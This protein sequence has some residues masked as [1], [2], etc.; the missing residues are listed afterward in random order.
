MAEARVLST[1]VRVGLDTRSEKYALQSAEI[2]FDGF[3][4]L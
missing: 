1:N 2:L 3:L 4:K